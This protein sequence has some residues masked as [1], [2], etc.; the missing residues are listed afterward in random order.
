MFLRLKK[1]FSKPLVCNWFSSC[2]SK[3]FLRAHSASFE[4]SQILPTVNVFL[5]HLTYEDSFLLE[6]EKWLWR[7]CSSVYHYIVA[8]VSCREDSSHHSWTSS[9]KQNSHISSSRAIPAATC[10]WMEVKT[11]V[12]S[13]GD[14][15]RK[16]IG[17]AQ[18]LSTRLGAVYFSW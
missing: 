15:K 18:Q 9:T 10:D 3:I 6:L 1:A 4:Y 5:D 8:S 14:Y 16:T 11:Q 2:S 17:G 7:G 12:E 13:L